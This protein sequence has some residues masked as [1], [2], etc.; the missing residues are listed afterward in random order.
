MV[1]LELFRMAQERLLKCVG[2]LLKLGYRER[3]ILTLGCGEVQL[4]F[5]GGGAH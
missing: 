4:R 1:R 3:T 2:R 5:H